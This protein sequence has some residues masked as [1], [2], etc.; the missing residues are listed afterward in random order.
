MAYQSSYSISSQ[1]IAC[2]ISFCFSSTV[3]SK[4]LSKASCTIKRKLRG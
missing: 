3:N 2:S 1:A 4:S